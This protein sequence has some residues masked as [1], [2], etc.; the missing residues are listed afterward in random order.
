MTSIRF[1]LIGMGQHGQRYAQH[2]LHDVAGAELYAICRRDPALGEAF[3]RQHNVRYYRE[4]LDLLNDPKV[5]AVAVVTP[6]QL[7]ERICSTAAMAGKAILV[8]KPMA[9]NGR[10]A[11]NIIE[12]VARSNSLFMV[13]HTLR[14]NAV[15]R[16]LEHHLD[17]IGLIHT[18]TMS[19]RA[20]PPERDWMDDFAQAGGGVIL[21]TGVHL[22]DLI[23]YFSDDEVRRV[24]CA[25]DRILYEELEDTFVAT[26]QLRR[27]N[28][29]CVVDA[30]RYT[31]SRSGRIEIVGEQ[32][33]LMGDFEHGYAMIIRGR[34]ASPLEVLPPV[35]TIIEGLKTFVQALQDDVE[36]P[37]SAVDGLR[38][39]EIA[40]ACYDA[41]SSQQAI[42]LYDEDEEDSLRD[43]FALDE[44]EP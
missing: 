43:G 33:Q 6:P 10:E 20:E 32:G 2:L 3:A 18:M 27:S 4:Y 39:V 8:E 16:A 31:G 12:A 7:H 41:V 25:S 11:I 38:A 14:F 36:P 29:H 34:Q 15:V 37:I 23:R 5:D 35:H 17:E 30:A 28:I 1:G 13:A 24:Y 42:D 40:E 9:L 44:W 19:Q 26:L 22:F 21:N